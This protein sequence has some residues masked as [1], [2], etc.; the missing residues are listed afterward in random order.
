[1]PK[2]A[3]D[4][5]PD[6]TL[7]VRAVG[8]SLSSVTVTPQKGKAV[9]G[10]L[11]G[12]QWTSSGFLSPTTTYELSA[13]GRNDAGATQTATS[14]FTTLTPRLTATYR[15]LPDGETVGVGMPAMVVFDSPVTTP[16][17]RAAV[18]RQVS[19]VTTPQ[20]EGA[21]GWSN[22]SQLLWRPQTFWKPGTKVSVNAPLTGLQTGDGKWV[23][24][25]AAATFTVGRARIS[26]V[27]LK[28]HKMTVT[29][30]G[31][32]VKTYPISGGQSTYKY[33]TRSGTKVIT[34]KLAHLTMDAATLGVAK[35]D[36]GYYKLDVNY[37][38]RVTN[39]GEFL[40]SAP[41][42][43]WAQGRSNV[44][45]GC[46]NMGPADAREMFRESLVGDVVHFTGSNRP[47]RPGD[48]M[49]AWVYSWKNWRAR[50]A[51]TATQA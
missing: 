37:A 29:E 26:T 16:A 33:I 36:P 32:V 51:L 17:Q 3:T 49:D 1:M 23:G 47:M 6:T 15:V 13:T 21:W 20:Q 12:P 24:R 7:R 34:E 50:S 48:G 46:T 18:E 30:A 45:H 11:D 27:D 38:M 39:T 44:S 25:N 41:W 35:S 8:G 31:K 2:G 5:R 28:R 10:S 19:I 14:T 43:V 42:S 22:N 4:V 40:H 9:E